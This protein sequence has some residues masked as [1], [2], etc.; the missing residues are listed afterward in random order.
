MRILALSLSMLIVGCAPAP[1]SGVAP[2]ASETP[3]LTV[4]S[5]RSESLVGPLF[6][7]I[8]AEGRFKIQVQYFG[9]QAKDFVGRQPCTLFNLADV[10]SP[11]TRC[12][13]KGILGQPYCLSGII[14][15]ISDF[16]HSRK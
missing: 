14:H 3:T 5:G 10:C 9:K 12:F 7:E 6:E 16:F 4:Y 1:E 11:D 15:N 2:G 8:E 13:A